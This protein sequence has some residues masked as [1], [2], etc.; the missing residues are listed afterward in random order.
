MLSGSPDI[1]AAFGDQRTLSLYNIHN[2]ESL[3]ILYK[4]DGKYIPSA[5]KKLN[6]IF[7]DWRRDEATK[8]DPKLFDIIWE[9]HTELGSKAPV[10]IISGYR[11]RKTNNMLRRTVGGQ[12][13]NSRHILGKAA[14][15]HIPDVPLK[16][17]R[18]SAMVRERG[19]VGYYPT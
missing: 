13:K 12:A 15:I 18:Y 8:M 10:H 17:M 9:I 2:K 14:D 7:R 5:L 3:T 19:G 11:S 16:E 1:T 6:W 4:K